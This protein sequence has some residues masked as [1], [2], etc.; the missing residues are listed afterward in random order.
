MKG[1]RYFYFVESEMGI[2]RIE[3]L[4]R[5][6]AEESGDV[7]GTLRN[8][9][10][11]TTIVVL[12]PADFLTHYTMH[13]RASGGLEV[14]QSLITPDRDDEIMKLSDERAKHVY[15]VVTDRIQAMDQG[16]VDGLRVLRLRTSSGEPG[17][18]STLLR[19]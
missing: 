5:L 2:S 3:N 4:L 6:M 10:S 14:F 15:A 11:Q 17:Y 9:K 13:H 19:R 8:L 7:A 1:V 18:P 12:S 16:F